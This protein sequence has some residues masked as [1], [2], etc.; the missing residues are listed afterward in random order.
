[1]LVIR[2]S[3]GVVWLTALLSCL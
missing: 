1:M 3:V 2:N